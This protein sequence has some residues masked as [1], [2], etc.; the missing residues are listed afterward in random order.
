MDQKRQLRKMGDV[1]T[2]GGTDYRLESV[3]GCGGS[4][5]VYR[6]RYEDRLNRGCYHNVL[7]KELFPAHP[8]GLICRDVSGSVCCQKD[9]EAYMERCRQS[10]YRGNQANLELLDLQPEQI[11]GNLNSFQAYGTYY[12]V[13]AVHGGKNLEQLLEEGTEVNSLRAAAA[14]MIKILNALECFHKNGIL[15]LDISPD[16]ILML[17][18][19]ALLIDYNSVWPMEQRD[20]EIR[21]FSIKEGYS[22]PE[23]RLCQE[24]SIGPAADLYSAAAVFFRILTGRRLTDDEV[25][26]SRL[27]K[28]FPKD[29]QIFRN[30]PVSAAKKAVQIVYRGLNILPRQR[31]QTIGKMRGDFEE[32]IR[33]ID[34]KGIS[35]SAIWETSRQGFREKARRDGLYLDRAVKAETG[36]M[37]TQ[38]GCYEKLVSGGRYLLKGPG[39][40]GKTCF[41]QELWGR[42]VRDYQSR[43]PVTVYIPLTDYQE[44]GEEPWYIRKYLLRRLCFTEQA[45]DMEEALHMLD[46]LFEKQNPEGRASFILLLDGLNEAGT[47][48]GG[49][50]KEIEEL[51]RK[52]GI[53]ILVTDRWDSVK[54]YGLHGFLTLEL[55]PLSEQAVEKELEKAGIPLPKEKELAGLLGN[56]MMLY[57]YRETVKVN[58]EGGRGLGDVEQI[59]GMEE[60]TG[61]YLDSLCI[62]GQRM[63][64][65]NQAEQLRVG[66]LIRH[67][68]P[69]LAGELKRRKKTLVTMEELYRIVQ[70]NYQS[71]NRKSFGMAF[72]E[73]MGKSRLMLKETAN[74]Q[75]WFDYAVSEQLISHLNL[76]EKTADGNFGLIHDN[77][78]GYLAD[79]CA[80]NKKKISRYRRKAWGLKGCATIMLA[81]VL[82]AGGAA[83]WKSRGPVQM[84]EEDR[85]VIRNA[86]SR[87]VLNLQILDIQAVSQRMILETARTDRVLDGEP[88]AVA[89][90]KQLIGK[91]SREL[92]KY[93]VMVNDGS[94]I[95]DELEMMNTEIPL[96]DL[97][98]LYGKPAELGAMIPDALFHLEEGLC[99]E[100]SPYYDRSKREALAEA[101]GEYLDAY[102]EVCYLELSRV[103]LSLDQ[104][105][106]DTVLDSVQEMTVFP[107]FILNHP[108]SG[109]SSEEL[110]VQ[111][112]AAKGRLKDKRDEMIMQNYQINGSG[113]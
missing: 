2:L 57:L 48:A 45:R 92:E 61:R 40:M 82:T 67:L 79:V 28:C 96:A 62:R 65:G 39:G 18:D 11:S 54:Q 97:R 9:G 13:L 15:H 56:P 43:M 33:R 107:E 27:G 91:K 24:D 36:E 98:D 53:G 3:E 1:I 6:A 100:D 25:V 7:I 78:I 106:A 84:S 90:L 63:N 52:P 35:H 64:S 108:L 31:Y 34:G 75:E 87:L 66:Y 55:L 72:P 41:L 51:G 26:G 69:E 23:V 99:G 20:G 93:D 30:Q 37:M 47:R 76:L 80:E 4:S 89:E 105:T 111:L 71:L 38:D 110:S 29:L 81:A 49:L 113:W 109:Q 101:Y 58:L 42:G 73:Y 22:A 70:K 88:E 86:A 46:R 12:S 77:F 44:A 94:R 60:M 17:E 112:D 103:L 32:L 14:C 85:L 8:Q 16:N 102:M 5:V 68:L 59:C 95:L 104:E 50:L 83:A 74:E 21:L 10:F 19:R